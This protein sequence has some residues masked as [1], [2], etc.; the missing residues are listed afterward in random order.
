MGGH[1][2]LVY[3]RREVIDPPTFNLPSPT[4]NND[5]SPRRVH[6][7]K[8]KWTSKLHYITSTTGPT[9]LSYLIH[10]C[11]LVMQIMSSWTQPVLVTQ[12]SLVWVIWWRT[13]LQLQTWVWCNPNDWL[14]FVGTFST[15]GN[16]LSHHM[17]KHNIHYI[18]HSHEIDKLGIFRVLT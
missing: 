17:L 8:K 11:C 13:P 1:F 18:G 4:S 15:V 16:V 6:L 9:S 10:C 7:A 3:C 2:F 12:P 5:Q 14:I